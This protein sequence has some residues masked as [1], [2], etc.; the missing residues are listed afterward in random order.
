MFINFLLFNNLMYERAVELLKNAV[1]KACKQHPE[2]GVMFSGGLDST[3]IATLANKFTNVTAYTSGVEDS[4]D[5]KYSKMLKNHVDFEIKTTRFNAEDIKRSLPKIVSVINGLD[6][7]KI[8]IEVP[9]YFSSKRANQDSLNLMLSGQGADQMF[10]GYQRYLNTLK[11]GDKALQEELKE[12]TENIWEEQL[13]LDCAVC[14]LNEVNLKFPYL[15]SK[16]R[17][18]VMN[19]PAKLK[20]RRSDE[21]SAVRYVE[22]KKF[23]KKYFLRKVGERVGIPESVLNRKKKAAQYG[24][25]AW[26]TIK[27]IAKSQSFKEKAK[28]VGRRNYVIA[29]FW[30]RFLLL[31]SPCLFKNSDIA[32]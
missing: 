2:V 7:V 18:Y 4:P 28:E 15:D 12:D 17:K 23:I 24:S 5:L 21:F 30:I 1:K 14:A 25:R 3:I 22:G 9:F 26:R 29:T 20:I 11:K 10:G 32:W 13:N 27:K 31:L 8:S 19:L 6:P 16:F